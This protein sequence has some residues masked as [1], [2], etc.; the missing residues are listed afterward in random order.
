LLYFESD[1][2]SRIIISI[3]IIK[4]IAVISGDS[5]PAGHAKGLSPLRPCKEMVIL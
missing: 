4:L 5:V 1:A 2:Y 3:R